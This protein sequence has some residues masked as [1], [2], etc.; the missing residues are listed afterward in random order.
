MTSQML[1]IALTLMLVCVFTVSAQEE[2]PSEPFEEDK[3]AAEPNV[4]F[5]PAGCGKQ[6]PKAPFRCAGG[7]RCVG[8]WTL[9]NGL[10]ACGDGSDE[11]GCQ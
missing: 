10:I 9:C 5:D 3:R 4:W 11:W 8:S 2:E 6:Y 1:Y 7:Y